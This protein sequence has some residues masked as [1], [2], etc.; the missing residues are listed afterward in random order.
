MDTGEEARVRVIDL[1]TL[2]VSKR[3]GS[4]KQTAGPPAD[5][6]REEK[7]EGETRQQ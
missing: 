2:I 3:P 7:E 1:E 5:A 6:R 4:E